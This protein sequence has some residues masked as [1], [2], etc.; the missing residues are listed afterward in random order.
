MVDINDIKAYASGETRNK[1]VFSTSCF[2]YLHYVDVGHLLATLLD[3]G[4][5]D[6]SMAL[7]RQVFGN[8]CRNEAIGAYLAIKNIGILFEPELRLNVRSL[9]D[10]GSIGQTLIVCAEGYMEYGVFHFMASQSACTIDLTGLSY[11]II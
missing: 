5:G 2:P 8:T 1:I 4:N 11:K 7:C 3:R 6:D 9:F 10:A